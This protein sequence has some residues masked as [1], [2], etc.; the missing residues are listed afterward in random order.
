[1]LDAM[2]GL[3]EAAPRIGATLGVIFVIVGIAVGNYG[4][5]GMGVIFALLGFISRAARP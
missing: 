4:I 5:V 3:R 1:M 2:D